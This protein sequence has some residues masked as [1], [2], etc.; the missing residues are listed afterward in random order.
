[1]AAPFGFI[2]LIYY[3]IVCPYLKFGRKERDKNMEIGIRGHEECIVTKELTAARIGSGALEVFATPMMLA[4]MEMAALRSVQPY[5]DEGCGTVGT[6]LDVSHEAATPLGMRVRFESEL[7]GIDG[8]KLIFRVEAYDECGRIG[9]GTH[10]R[11]IISNDRFM[12]KTE[13]KLA[14][15]Q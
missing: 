11:F 10:E 8:R 9:S 2:T 14:A 13:A 5:L 15:K 4:F 1:M 12:K 3:T 7:I 6:H